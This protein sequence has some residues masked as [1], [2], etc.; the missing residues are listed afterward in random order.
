MSW[1]QVK[2]EMIKEKGLEE[3][4]ANKLKEFVEMRGEVS[5]FFSKLEESKKM[6][7]NK[8]CET[9]IKEMKTLI[10]YLTIFGIAPFIEIDFSLARGLNYYTG[11]I[12]EAV[13]VN[14]KLSVG[15]IGG[16]GRYDN[17]TSMFGKVKVP[18]I[19]FS[20]GV[21][22]IFAVLINRAEK[23]KK[24]LRTNNTQVFIASMD[25]CLEERMKIT[26]ELWDNG[27]CTE[28]ML[29]KKPKIK[30]QLGYANEY[31]VQLA[32]IFGSRE[33]EAGVVQLKD[34]ITTE[35]VEIPRSAIV[36]EVKKRL[37]K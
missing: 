5:S 25:G 19:G 8:T 22:R 15:S 21:E 4:I 28:F 14:C 31:Q 26:R 36:E 2:E 20:V 29:K 30:S 33:L 9:T 3:E 24:K 34:L 35:Q 7:G 12:F 1:E 16:G 23:E 10:E 17:L 13:L 18:C 11:I 32:I 37:F 6:E 27:I